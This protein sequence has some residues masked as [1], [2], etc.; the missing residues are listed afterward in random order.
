[1]RVI[2]RGGEAEAREALETVCRGY[3]YPI[4][5]YLRRSGHSQTDAEDLT[6]GFFQRLIGQKALETADREAG[7][8]RS[9]LL[10]VLKRHLRDQKR[11]D[12]RLKRGGGQELVSFD[13]AVAEARYILEPKDVN[14]PDR[15]FDR[16]WAVGVLTDAS[17][18]LRE[19]FVEG[20]N[21]A[22]FEHLSEFLPLGANS[23]A[24]RVIAKRLGIKEDSVRLQVRRMRQRYRRIIEERIGETVND[25]AE[26][27][28]E[29]Q[30][31][32]AALGPAMTAEW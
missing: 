32:M 28:E 7:R 3:W 14:T 20:G 2:Q 22:A 25:P 4:Y 24:Y 16:A 15:L 17:A 23:T 29:L 9:Y 30:H 19:F 26:I 1:V 21:E 18:T 5:A 13:E 11:H 8:L 6:Q 12:Q 10:G 27:E 31:L